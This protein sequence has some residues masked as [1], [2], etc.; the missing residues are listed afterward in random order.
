MKLTSI[1]EVIAEDK[2]YLFSGIAILSILIFWANFSI[3]S[4]L[5]GT[6]VAP[7]YITI[8]TV[9]CGNIFFP[10]KSTRFKASY[11]FLIFFS[12]IVILGSLLYWIRDFSDSSF[13]AVLLSLTISL[14]SLRRSRLFKSKRGGIDNQRLGKTVKFRVGLIDFL[15]FISLALSFY[16]LF[17]ARTGESI[18]SPWS[19]VSNWF[20]VSLFLAKVLLMVKIFRGKT[21]PILLLIYLI[22]IIFVPASGYLIVL[23]HPY[24]TNMMANNL[25]GDRRLTAYGRSPVGKYKLELG[26]HIGNAA[27]IKIFQCDPRSFALLFVPALFT[28]IVVFATFDLVSLLAPGKRRLALLCSASFLASQHNIF[29]FTPPGK[30]ESLALGM[31][32][33]NIMFWLMYLCDKGYRATSVTAS[34]VTL[35]AIVLIH[36]YVGLFAL[37]IAVLALAFSLFRPFH[38]GILRAGVGFV[39]VSSLLFTWVSCF[40]LLHSFTT[41]LVGYAPLG[42]IDIG[43]FTVTNFLKTIAPTIWLWKGPSLFEQL[44][45]TFINNS[46]YL[47]YALI[48]VGVFA[49]VKY[50]LNKYWLTMSLSVILLALAYFSVVANF[51]TIPTMAASNSYRFFYYLNFLAFPLMGT[52][53]YWVISH[54]I[55]PRI[56]I[57]YIARGRLRLVLLKPVQFWASALILSTIF[58]SSIYAGY[59]REGSMGPYRAKRPCWPSD[60]DV[61]ALDF[62]KRSEEEKRDF[63][64]VA[65]EFTNAAGLVTLGYQAIPTPPGYGPIFSFFASEIWGANELWSLAVNRPFE[66]LR[67]GVNFTNSI[68]NRTYIILTYRLGEQRLGQLL[69]V[70]SQFLGDPLYIIEGKVYAF[71]YTR[72]HDRYTPV[73]DESEQLILA[74]DDQKSFWTLH[75]IGRGNLNVTLKDNF[76]TKVTGNN[77]LEVMFSEGRY[78]RATLRHVWPR[79]LN[80]SSMSYVLLLFRGS[81]SNKAFSIIF[82][83]PTAND[84]YSYGLKDSFEGWRLIIIPLKS[85]EAHGS[86][87]WS[88]VKE[89]LFFFWSGWLTGAWYIDYVVVATRIPIQPLAEDIDVILLL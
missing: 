1:N 31:L 16:L 8:N 79:P 28:V 81:G 73:P 29:L 72:Q 58:T 77:S 27:L 83:A 49:A 84:F 15:F 14:V 24:A 23:H 71:Y 2:H 86:P 82:R 44:L 25:E 12:L 9:F 59:P 33:V 5:V 46:A 66:Y 45:L 3:K 36:Q 57:A 30:P 55:Y 37:F 13:L 56:W 4:Q 87:S 63:F 60:Y 10:H 53:M 48:L 89:T 74:D 54:M 38:G 85:F 43:A 6:I 61:S 51:F 20:Y 11:G 21:H 76:T 39:L 69:G 62:I 75:L 47:T 42:H 19:V 41:I 40:P 18:P 64:V 50:D 52:G 88:N 34:L 68:A 78:E 67:D 26:G 17:T 32:L 22:L 7:L 80:L 35:A 70:Y 65:D